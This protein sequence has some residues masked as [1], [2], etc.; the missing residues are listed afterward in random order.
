MQHCFIAGSLESTI[1]RNLPSTHSFNESKSTPGP[2]CLLSG[3][4][5]IPACAAALIKPGYSRVG[6]P[7]TSNFPWLVNVG[8]SPPI[9]YFPSCPSLILQ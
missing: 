5:G 1:P 6:V 3:S 2:H 4:H 9:A 7:Y 8:K